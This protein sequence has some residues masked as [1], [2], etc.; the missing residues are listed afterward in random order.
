MVLSGYMHSSGIAGL[1]DSFIPSFLRNLLLFSIVVVSVC[2]PTNSIRSF[3]FATPSPAFIVHRLFDDGLSDQC[4]M[5]PHCSF[6]LLFSNSEQCSASLH[7]FVSHL[8]V[9]F[10]KM[11][12]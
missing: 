5:I 10:G 11:S 6:D 12:V 2:L 8:Y 3:P 9:F 1:Y 4:E 7:V